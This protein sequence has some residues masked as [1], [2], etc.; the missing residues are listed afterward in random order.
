MAPPA[1]KC[2]GCSALV[3]NPVS[4]SDC[5]I[6]THAGSSCLIRAG[7][8]WHNGRL[9]NCG[10]GMSRS[11]VVVDVTNSPS[12]KSPSAFPTIDEI[13]DVMKGFVEKQFNEFR[14]EMVASIR[15][16]L[17]EIR[18][19]VGDLSNRVRILEEN[20]LNVSDR[21]VSNLGKVDEVIAE[22]NDTRAGNVIIHELPNATPDLARG[23]DSDCV[24]SILNQIQ[25]AEYADIRLQRLG[26]PKGS[27]SR[28]L[29]DGLKAVRNILR[30][31][32][33]YSGPC[34]IADDKTLMQRQSLD[35]LRAKLRELR[36]S[37]DTSVTIRYTYG[38]PGIVPIK[39]AR[40]PASKNQ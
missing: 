1:K 39:R 34:K 28:P 11:A 12:A 31:K 9:L 2:N 8:P 26:K 38:V 29:C 25:P 40:D 21:S 7:H 6:I 33:R 18:T 10:H 24:R 36:D 22:I 30:N 23:H 20:P 27:S 3:V 13:N 17:G 16:E 32:S 35:H 19:T 14:T 15:S 37:G 4:C 5:G